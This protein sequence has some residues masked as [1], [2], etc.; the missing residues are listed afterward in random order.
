METDCAR[1]LARR[2]QAEPGNFLPKTGVFA[3]RKLLIINARRRQLLPKPLLDLSEL[4]STQT[5]RWE[6]RT[7]NC[8]CCRGVLINSPILGWRNECVER[9]RQLIP[10]LPQLRITIYHIGKSHCG[11]GFSVLGQTEYDSGIPLACGE[12]VA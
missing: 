7:H 10:E 5:A 1:Q 9:V 4:I 2:K 11:P 6:L 3:G 12:V 8:F